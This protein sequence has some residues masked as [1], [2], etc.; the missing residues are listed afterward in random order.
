MLDAILQTNDKLGAPLPDTIA[1]EEEQAERLTRPRS[2]LT[3]FIKTVESP[4]V[5]L[6]AGGKMGPTLAALAR[7]AAEAAGHAL[8]VVAVS[9]FSDPEIRS[10]LQA[11]GIRTLSL[12]LMEP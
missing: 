3:A 8:E 2:D 12:D 10:W 6:G 1:S 4:L 5:I 9:R 11:R 7:R